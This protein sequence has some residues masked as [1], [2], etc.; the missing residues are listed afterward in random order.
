MTAAPPIGQWGCILADPP[1]YFANRS[2]A[3]EGKNPVAH[4]DCMLLADIMAMDMAFV[5][6]ADCA[7]VMWATA[8][9]LPEALQV[10]AAWG[11]GFKTAGAWAKQ[12]STG[13]EWAFGTGYIVRSAAEFILVGTRDEP[14]IKSKSV[15]NLIVAPIREH[16]RKPDA[17]HEMCEALFDGPFLELFGR[18]PR[19]GWTVWG[20]Q[21][22]KFAEVGHG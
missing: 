14:R 4:Y 6:A 10:M 17:A 22:D 13:Q 3:G 9:M 12:S 7:L 19:E 8:P 18:A 21:A 20:N 2:E 15:R 5:G 11:F 1:W 16:S